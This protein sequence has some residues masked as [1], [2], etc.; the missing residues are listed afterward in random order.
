MQ[1]SKRSI[2]LLLLLGMFLLVAPQATAQKKF[3]ASIGR[4]EL[5]VSFLNLEQLN[6][7]LEAD[8]YLPLRS[9]VFSMGFS[10]NRFMGNFVYGGKLYNYMIAKAQQD[11]QLASMN[12]HYLIPYIGPVFYKDGTDLMVYGTVGA[13][14]GIANLKART[15]GQQ[16]HTNYNDSGMILDAALHVSRKFSE[17]EG[18]T[19][20]FEMG[21]SLGYMYTRDGAFLLQDFGNTETGIPVS[22]AGIYFRLTLGM[23]TWQ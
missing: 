21:F 11:Y 5:G 7:A 16:L 6:L 3:R 17:V 18:E 2:H 14:L 20:G 15:L 8:D 22:P 9:N 12:F 13:G 10:A 23:I 4:A 1:N 19:N